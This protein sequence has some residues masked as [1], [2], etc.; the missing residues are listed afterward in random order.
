MGSQSS[1]SSEPSVDITESEKSARNVLE[2]FAKDI[3]GKSSSDAEKHG[4]SLKG[5]LRQAK[6]YQPLLMEA[7]V[8]RKVPSNPCNLNYIFHTNVWHGNAED[9]HP[10]RFRDTKRFSDNA[11]AICT[12]NKINGNEG[13]TGA[14]APYRRRHVCDY[15][16]EFID[17]HRIRN[18]H[19]LLGNVLVMAKSEGESL[20]NSMKNHSSNTYKYSICNALAETFADIGDIIRGKDLYLGYSEEEK[21]NKKKVQGN[22]RSIFAAIY[23]NLKEQ[24]KSPYKDGE[25]DGN[26]YKLRESWW[27]LNRNDVWK[28]LTCSAPEDAKYV[29]YFPSNTTTVSS[30]KCGH[31]DMDVPT[32]LDYVPQ[33]L[34]WFNEWS[35]QFCRKRNIKLKKVMDACHNDSKQLYCSHNGYDCTKTIRNENILSDDPKCTGCLVK[36]SLYDSWLKNQRNEFEKQKEKY[37]H[38]IETYVSNTDISN[39]NINNEYYK[40]FYDQLNNKYKN[41]EDFLM[42]LNEGRYCKKNKNTKEEE[43]IDFTKAHEKGTFSHSKHCKVC[44]YC[45]VVCNNGTCTAKPE[46]YPNC[47]NNE[48][49]S[50]GSAETTEITVLYSGDKE[51]Y[52]FEKLEDFCTTTNNENGKNYE[53]WKCYYNNKKNNNKCKMEINGADRKLNNKIKSFDEV[54]D[55]WVKNLLRDSI[56]W[57]NELKDC[58]NNTNV[59]DCNA[60]C[61]SNCVCFDKWLKQKEDEWTNMMKLFNKEHDIP[62][63]YKINI[64]KL[65]NSYF[66]QVMFELNKDEAQWKELTE[67]LKKKIDS[68]NIINGKEN[69]QDAI[70]LLLEYLKENATIC[71]DNNTNEACDPTVDS[72]RNPCMKNTTTTGGNN[73]RATVKQIAQYYKRLAHAQLEKRGG[74]SNLKGDASKGEYSR[75][76]SGDDFK[77]RLCSITEKHSN[78]HSKSEKPC[79]GKDGTGQRFIIGNDWKDDKFVSTTHK[80]VYMPPRRQHFCTSNLEYLINGGHQAILR[81]QNG[82]INSSFLGDVLLAAKYQ[83]QH[84]MKDYKP[85]NDKEGKCRA[86]RYSFAD[87]GD[88]IRG[89]DMWDQNGG[90]IKTQNNLKEIFKKIKDELKVKYK[91]DDGKHTQLRSDWWEA[92]R[93]QIWK[94]MQCGNDNPCSRE[95]DHTPLDDYIPQRLRWMTEWTEWYCKAQ[96]KYYGELKE[97]CQGCKGKGKDCTESDNDCKQCMKACDKYKTKIEPWKKQWKAMSDKYTLLYSNARIAAINGGPRYSTDNVKKEDQSVYDFLYNLYVQ[98]GGK[99][100][101]PPSIHGSMRVNEPLKQVSI[102]DTTPTVYSTAEGYVHQELPNMGCVSQTQFCEKSGGN[103]N[104]AFEETP[105]EF[106]EACG[107]KERQASSPEFKTRSENTEEAPRPL[108]PHPPPPSQEETTTTQINVCETVK[109][110]LQDPK[111]LQD[112]CKLKYVTGKNYGWRCINDKTKSGSSDTT[113][114]SICVPP[115]RRKLYLHK[116][117]G[118]GDITDTKTLSEWFVKSAAVETFFLWDRYKKIKEQEKKERKQAENNLVVH[119]ASDDKDEEQKKLQEKGEIPEEFKRQMFYNLGDYRDILFGNKEVIETLKKSGDDNIKTI[120]DKIDKI[121]QKNGTPRKPGEKPNS[122]REEFWKKHG[123]DIWQGMICSGFRVSGFRVQGLGLGFRV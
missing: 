46:R 74:R 37:K 64:N 58:R 18:T 78:A 122:K 7:G 55:L 25:K 23:K 69:S 36:C 65:F 57:E 44:P 102:D 81:V 9:R 114:G 11:E 60:G 108:P 52:I 5:N 19:D 47:E 62:Q 22:L 33:F 6:F 93:D 20:T 54:F 4:Y 34:R 117:E 83:A 14:C 109:N 38:E 43:D 31:K 35:E 66:F 42:L 94:A 28:A 50:P 10:C 85:Q 51:G 90:E 48:A 101:P 13:T 105:K 12:N 88:I 17:V 24:E 121:L 3:K 59:T 97:G 63:Q 86:I 111:N 91:D 15:N 123:K 39:S 103:T 21:T 40:T 115:R 77:D 119:A 89:K 26:Y 120:T 106:G 79:H 100:G 1:K 95:S 73:K 68:S 112:A 2:G 75:N 76:G 110:A 99:V 118:D 84:T 98:N 96:N 41:H 53:K 104:Y 49:Y 32:N 92:N 16:L 80:D 72:K 27:A 71:K 116:I 82:K 61:N 107:C 56:K 87:I 113:A 70:K 67:E 8:H 45:G 29:K 30:N